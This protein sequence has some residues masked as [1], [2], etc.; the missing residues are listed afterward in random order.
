MVKLAKDLKRGD[1]ITLSKGDRVIVQEN[2]KTGM[3]PESGIE[4]RIIVFKSTGYRNSATPYGDRFVITGDA[5][6]E[7]EET[8]A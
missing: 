3:F 1:I 4:L 7:L 6:Y 2:L 8:L 5:E